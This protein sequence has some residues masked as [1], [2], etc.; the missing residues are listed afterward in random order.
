[1]VNSAIDLDFSLEPIRYSKISLYGELSLYTYDWVSDVV[2]FSAAVRTNLSILELKSTSQ[3]LTFGRTSSSYWGKG[4]K[5][6]GEPLCIGV[7]TETLRE[8]TNQASGRL[9]RSENE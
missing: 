6:P 8:S 1:M 7:S 4:G 2:D 9:G 5:P 3:G